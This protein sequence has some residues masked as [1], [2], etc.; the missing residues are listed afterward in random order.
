[1]ARRFYSRAAYPNVAHAARA[2]I[3]EAHAAPFTRR[4][5][6]ES[7]AVRFGAFRDQ[8]AVHDEARVDVE[9]HVDTRLD[10]ERLAG[11]HDD[12][13]TYPNR[14]IRATPHTGCCAA[15]RTFRHQRRRDPVECHG[16]AATERDQVTVVR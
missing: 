13:A 16:I 4:A 1:M 5:E 15:N 11:R 14:A 12:V 7:N 6:N 2:T 9:Q 10:A 8:F 3:R